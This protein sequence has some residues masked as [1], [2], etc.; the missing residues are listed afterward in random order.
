MKLDPLS[1]GSISPYINIES[2]D[3]MNFS[4]AILLKSYSTYHHYTRDQ[5]VTKY[6]SI[7]KI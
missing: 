5:T 1:R 4:Y 6:S 3:E 7:L 2:Q